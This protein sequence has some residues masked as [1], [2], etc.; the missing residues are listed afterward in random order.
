MND[1]YVVKQTNVF[2]I[3]GTISLYWICWKPLWEGMVKLNTNGVCQEYNR[4]SCGGVI[5]DNIGQWI[6]G[7][8]KPLGSCNEFVAELW[9]AFEDL[10]YVQSLGH[11]SLELNVDFMTITRVNK[12]RV[13]SSIVGL[14]GECGAFL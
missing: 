11:D 7:F 1:C 5:R 13:S 10:K 9:G 4:A 2:S 8:S 14:R 6:G 3:E 12:N